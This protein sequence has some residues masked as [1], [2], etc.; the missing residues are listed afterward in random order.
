MDVFSLWLFLLYCSL[1]VE[2]RIKSPIENLT[3]Y[4]SSPI[5][6]SVDFS[7]LGCIVQ[8]KGERRSY[9]KG[10]ILVCTRHDASV[11]SIENALTFVN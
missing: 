5:L 1:Y 3:I 7:I 4:T 9:V 10:V 6:F 2:I 8:L 11:V